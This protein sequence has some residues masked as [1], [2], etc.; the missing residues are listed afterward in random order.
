MFA[1][2]TVL[3]ALSIYSECAD[4]LHRPETGPFDELSSREIYNSYRNLATFLGMKFTDSHYFQ[5][6]T[7]GCTIL[8]LTNRSRALH[9]ALEVPPKRLRNNRRFPRNARIALFTPGEEFIHEYIVPTRR[10]AINIVEA[11]RIPTLKRPVDEIESGQLDYFLNQVCNGEDFA[12]F[13]R[14]FYGG[15]YMYFGG[16]NGDL[17]RCMQSTATSQNTTPPSY[18]SCLFGMFASPRV[19]AENPQRRRTVFRLNR[20][21]PPYNQHPIDVNIEVGKIL[22]HVITSL[23]GL[24]MFPP[25]R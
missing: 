4:L 5:P 25:T 9:I 22:Y 15:S 11:R 20:F 12:A 19:M 1:H 7:D 17:P 10:N 16:N 2:L 24:S 13:L 18:I 23:Y 14:D 21:V 8:P 3:L 6:I